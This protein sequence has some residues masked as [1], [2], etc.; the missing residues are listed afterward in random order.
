MLR[1]VIVLQG[2]DTGAIEIIDPQTGDLETIAPYGFGHIATDPDRTNVWQAIR[3]EAL[4]Q[5]K[6]ILIEDIETD[7]DFAERSDTASSGFR[8]VQSTPLFDVAGEPIGVLS[9][10][11]HQLHR[12]SGADLLLTDLYVRHA[13]NMIERHHTQAHLSVNEERYRALIHTSTNAV[14]RMSADGEELLEIGGGAIRPHAVEQGP[15]A[16]WLI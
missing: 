10:G 4:K 8:V 12:S 2:A 13:A 5:R 7:E 3:D 11:F 1:A 9:I 14:W 15:S 16:A 6:H